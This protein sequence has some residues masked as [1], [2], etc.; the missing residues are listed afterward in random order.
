MVLVVVWTPALT[1]QVQAVT[2]LALGTKPSPDGATSWQHTDPETSSRAK[3]VGSPGV[4]WERRT[5]LVPWECNPALL[6]A[7]GT[8]K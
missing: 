5:Q 7:P 8:Q 1:I 6:E 3:K 2:V 4:A